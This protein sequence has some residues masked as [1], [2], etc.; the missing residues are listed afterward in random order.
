[1]ASEFSPSRHRCLQ[2]RSDDDRLRRGEPRSPLPARLREG[3][4]ECLQHREGRGVRSAAAAPAEHGG[5]LVRLVQPQLLLAQR[6]RQEH[7][8]AQ[9][10]AWVREHSAR[11]G[12]G[13]RGG[14]W[15]ARPALGAAARLKPA[16]CLP[17]LCDGT[18]RAGV[19]VVGRANGVHGRRARG[20]GAPRRAARAGAGAAR[21]GSSGHSQ[22]QGKRVLC[23]R[24]GSEAA[25]RRAGR[26]Q[27][28]AT[29]ASSSGSRPRTNSVRDWHEPS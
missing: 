18:P 15:R 20:R 3:A 23:G 2:N 12:S 7:G 21:T 5:A 17:G 11:G 27:P 25:A 28:V 4:P 1:M 13:T 29:T 22:A 16:A 26:R 9:P 8:P 19:A 6:A 14:T 10:H 24:L